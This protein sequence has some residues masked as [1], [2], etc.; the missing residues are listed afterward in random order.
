MSS[1]EAN[2]LFKGSCRRFRD[3]DSGAV[4]IDVLTGGYA[5]RLGKQYG[6]AAGHHIVGVNGLNVERRSYNDTINL[7]LEAGRP[8]QLTIFNPFAV[9]NETAKR[10][11]VRPTS[12]AMAEEGLSMLR[13]G[14]DGGAS[15]TL[16]RSNQHHRASS[17]P[18][19]LPPA[20]NKGVYQDTKC[21]HKSCGTVFRFYPELATATYNS[22]PVA[23]CPSCHKHFEM[24][25]HLE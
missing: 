21:P 4:I 1:I 14:L 13:R 10:A 19:S 24:I 5:D 23:E 17:K 2:E 15:V 8:L 3:V 16:E 20:L 11:S 6:I 22:N 9:T 7:I 18:P 12:S 25:L